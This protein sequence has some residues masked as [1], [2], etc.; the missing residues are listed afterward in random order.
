VILVGATCLDDLGQADPAVRGDLETAA[1]APL[2]IAEVEE[3]E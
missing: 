1:W 3:E 2:F